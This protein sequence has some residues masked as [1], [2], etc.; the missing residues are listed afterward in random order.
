MVNLSLI[1]NFSDARP[2]HYSLLEI[3]NQL[4]AD[5][6]PAGIKAA[7]SILN[8]CENNLRLPMVPI[9]DQYFSELESLIQNF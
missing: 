7:L 2:I 3:I 6:N 9:T 4:F 8:I 5:G 1:R